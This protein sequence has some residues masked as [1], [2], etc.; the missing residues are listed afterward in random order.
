MKII[1]SFKMTRCPHDQEKNA[2]KKKGNQEKLCKNHKYVHVLENNVFTLELLFMSET[3][4]NG[5]CLLA[6]NPA[7]EL[8]GD[9]SWKWN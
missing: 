2:I 9:A 1:P 5:H 8:P 7:E 6:L 3:L 4:N